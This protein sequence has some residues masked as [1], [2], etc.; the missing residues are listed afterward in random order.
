[1]RVS[2]P[3]SQRANLKTPTKITPESGGIEKHPGL[4]AKTA[5]ALKQARHYDLNNS[6]VCLQHYIQSL[7]M[8]KRIVGASLARLIKARDKH[9]AIKPEVEEPTS[10]VCTKCGNE[11]PIEE[12]KVGGKIKTI[13]WSCRSDYNK[14]YRKKTRGYFGKIGAKEEDNENPDSCSDPVYAHGGSRPGAE[15]IAD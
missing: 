8:D 14:K 7:E 3:R 15:D 4:K 2:F 1:M 6:I 11:R 12:F 10:G 13:C 9:P 5:D